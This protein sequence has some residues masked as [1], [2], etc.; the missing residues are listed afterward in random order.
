MKY[1]NKKILSQAGLLLVALIW[2]GGFIVVKNSLADFSPLWLL[3]ARFIVAA[4]AAPILFHRRIRHIDKAV[5]KTGAVSGL[6][7]YAG[8]VLQTVGVQYT[9]ASKNALLTSVY[10]VLVPFVYWLM[11]R[12]RPNTLQ[13]VSA[14]I[15]FC[16]IF[17][18]L[19]NG[20]FGQF[21]GGDLLTLACGAVFAV[22]ISYLGLHSK[23]MD[24]FALTMVQIAVCA[25]ASVVCAAIFEPG[26]MPERI[27]PDML[28]S[29]AYL[30]LLSTLLAYFVQ[31]AAQKYTH[32]SGAS[33]ILSLE[34]AIGAVLSVLVFRDEFTPLMWAGGAL[35]FGA[36]IMAQL[37]NTDAGSEFASPRPAKREVC[38]DA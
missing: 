31:T 21:N 37:K 9:T 19:Y 30:G 26:K 3:A 8:F 6:L 7:I 34:C 25:G 29:V 23:K 5:L 27:H 15:C 11:V 14:L 24:S 4:V 35:T 17:L 20:D 18:L 36:V 13:I 28:L 12:K 2:G 10:V 22:Q 38:D 1:T 16:G 32:P 33:L